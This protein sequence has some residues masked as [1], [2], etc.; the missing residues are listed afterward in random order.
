MSPAL[1]TFHIGDTI[2]IRMEFPVNMEDINSGDF[3]DMSNFPFNTEIVLAKIDE[4]PSHS[5]D[6]LVEYFSTQGS[7]TILPLTGGGKAVQVGFQNNS[8]SFLFSGDV[9]LKGKGIFAINSFSYFLDEFNDEIIP[10]CKT[11]S[12][13]ISYPITLVNASSDANFDL[14]QQSPDPNISQMEEQIFNKYGTFAFEVL[15]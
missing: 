9:V 3:V 7:L 10:D 8:N 14:I 1:D 15:E 5:G 11:T 4:N 12:V 13:D 2:H 6:S